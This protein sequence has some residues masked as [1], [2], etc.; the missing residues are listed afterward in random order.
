MGTLLV[1][2][3]WG[4]L[5]K[6]VL[7]FALAQ[8]ARFDAGRALRIGLLLGQ[9]GE[10]SFLLADVASADTADEAGPVVIAVGTVS[11][12]MSAIA[13][14]F[15]GPLERA[16][17]DAR[18]VRRRPPSALQVGTAAPELQQHTVICG[19][20]ETGRE[21]ARI[22]DARDFHY[23]VIDSDPS[24]LDELAGGA[25]PYIWGDLANAA[26]LDEAQLDTA[27]VVAVTPAG[28]SRM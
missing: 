5:G 9:M 28:S 3:A 16:I 4:T 14:R 7:I 24:L 26:T 25:I 23:L 18:F 8:W 2:S 11:I 22:L 21:L 17:R 20:G 19:Y 15:S 10:F 12:A 6:V 13:L 27:R 1:A